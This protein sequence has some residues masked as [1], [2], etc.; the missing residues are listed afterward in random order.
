M[1]MAN[2]AMVKMV[3]EYIFSDETKQKVITALNENVDIPIIGEKTEAKIL[4]AIWNTMEEVFKKVI[5]K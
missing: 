3:S 2:S 5:L 1:A 4:E